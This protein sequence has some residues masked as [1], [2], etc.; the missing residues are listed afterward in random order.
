MKRL[1]L[2]L[3]FAT[4]F[5]AVGAN[6]TLSDRHIDLPDG[7]QPEGIASGGG[8]KLYVGSIPT[9]A[10]LKLDPRSGRTRTVVA[11]GNDRAAIG[12]KH[13]GRGRL[14]VAGG[15]TG[16]AFVYSARTGTE[17]AQFQLAPTGGP[18]G[19]PTFVNDVALTRKGAWF[20]DSRRN[21]LYF[22]R[23]D[24]ST[25]RELPLAGIT[26]AEGNNLNGIVSASKHKLIAVQGNAGA[27]WRIDARTGAARRIDL[28]G[29][30]LANGDGLLLEGRKLYAVQNRLNQI[31]VVKLNR[32]LTR[33]AVVR[34]VKSSDFDVPTTLARQK[35]AL[36][37]VNARFGTPAGPE[38]EYWVTKLGG[39]KHR[40]HRRGDDGRDE[41]RR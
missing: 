2:V 28:G 1:L 39:K 16:K 4:A 25:A 30:T 14:F 5:I 38:T 11:G 22:V 35:G 13:D 32:R 41:R 20:T 8:N 33:G 19:G 29:A 27:L 10:V 26:L 6:A 9:G 15:Q 24:L 23:R 17:L 3:V 34:T 18:T 21:S 12:L 31:A 37:A 7:W 36:F 40:G